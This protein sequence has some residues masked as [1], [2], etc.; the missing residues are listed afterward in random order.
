MNIKDI[1]NASQALIYT[2]E[3]AVELA[4]AKGDPML[5]V[6][7][8]DRTLV[9]A[10]AAATGRDEGKVREALARWYGPA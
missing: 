7:A 1:A 10:L 2:V 6:Q 9:N 5:A 3:E 8:I 4:S